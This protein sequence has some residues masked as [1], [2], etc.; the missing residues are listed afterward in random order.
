M[1]S[2][3][4]QQQI[5]EAQL[6]AQIE[7]VLAA[8]AAADTSVSA[9][10]G[11][12]SVLHLDRRAIEAAYKIATNQ[13]VGT[14]LIPAVIRYRRR[15]P[16]STLGRWVGQYEDVL[17]NPK[18]NRPMLSAVRATRRSELTYRAAYLLNAARRIHADLRAGRSIGQA[19]GRERTNWAAHLDARDRRMVAAADIDVAAKAYGD[20]LGWYSMD[21]ARTSEECRLAG[22]HN[23]HVGARPLIG[24]PGTV[25]PNCRCRPG[26]P[27]DGAKTVDQVFRGRVGAARPTLRRRA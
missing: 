20:L 16:G 9:V 5:D 25:H 8:G 1:A 17:D 27:Y 15:R 7:V 23:F 21:D 19:M 11:A 13:P 2:G 18:N 6:I 12:L 22:G 14:G 10:V 24:Y 26:M 3:G 4:Q